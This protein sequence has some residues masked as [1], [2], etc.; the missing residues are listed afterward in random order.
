VDDFWN[1][2]IVSGVLGALVA[3]GTAVHY[4]VTVADDGL[5]L[6]FG[7][8]EA[9][10]DGAISPTELKGAAITVLSSRTAAAGAQN[11]IQITL[12]G[13]LAQ[14]FFSAIVVQGTD[15]VY[16]RYSTADATFSTFG[17]APVFSFWN[18]TGT[19]TAWTAAGTREALLYY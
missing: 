18:W 19:D 9:E 2:P 17:S 4:S 3:A 6:I 12:E 14:S 13:D 16:R 7:F 15:G 1:W 10:G 8:N 5:G 11:N